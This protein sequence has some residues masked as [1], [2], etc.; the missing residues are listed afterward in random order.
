MG[1]RARTYRVIVALAA[2]SAVFCTIEARLGHGWHVAA[3]EQGAW[4][5]R[6]YAIGMDAG[7]VTNVIVA[8]GL[9]GMPS[10]PLF[11]RA[12]QWRRNEERQAVG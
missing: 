12:T 10:A 5:T 3:L 9:R 8:E 11:P 7:R 6:A 1:N 2:L 4:M